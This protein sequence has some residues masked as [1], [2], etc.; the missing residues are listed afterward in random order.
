LNICCASGLIPTADNKS[1]CAPHLMTVFGTC[2]SAGNPPNPKTGLCTTTV[3]SLQKCAPGYTQIPDGSCCLNRFVSP[4]GKT[5]G[6]GL[7]VP[8]VIPVPSIAGCGPNMHKDP[9]SGLCVAVK[10]PKLQQP[11]C[12]PNQVLR[13]NSCVDK[14]RRRPICGPNQILRGNICV[15]V[16]RRPIPAPS[17][18]RFDRRPISTPLIRRFER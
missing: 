3:K 8:P 14:I 16:I 4:D 1:C 9:R 2:C 18:R 11:T 12:G 15:N 7:G 5:C 6:P 17:I 13:G 10:P